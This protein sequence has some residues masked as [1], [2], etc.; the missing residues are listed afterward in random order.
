MILL[1]IP[2]A[3][4]ALAALLFVTEALERRSS[5]AFVRMALRSRR[6][7]EA[8]EV[9]VAAELAR[10]LEAAGLGHRPALALE[11]AGRMEVDPV[12]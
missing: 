12:A 3:L 2:V 10:R 9:V 4:T 11:P 5:D 6:T 1:I 8:T 7:P